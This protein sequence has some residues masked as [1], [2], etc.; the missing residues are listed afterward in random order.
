[1]E[2]ITDLLIYCEVEVNPCCWV[3]T[4]VSELLQ[5]IDAARTSRGEGLFFG[6]SGSSACHFN[7][8]I[9]IERKQKRSRQ[10]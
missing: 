5:E 4:V 6:S 9:M 3:L 2:N 1:M 10:T 7:F 8:R